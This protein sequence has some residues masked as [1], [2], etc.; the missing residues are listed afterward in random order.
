MAESELDGNKFV[1]LPAG[2]GLHAGAP[3]AENVPGPHAE[4]IGEVEPAPQA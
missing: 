3:A 4:P 2:V 1:N